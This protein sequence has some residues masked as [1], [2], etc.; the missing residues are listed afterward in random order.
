MSTPPPTGR[1][2]AG[3]RKNSPS[4]SIVTRNGARKAK[5]QTRA[6]SAGAKPSAVV[7]AAKKKAQMKKKQ[8]PTFV[9]RDHL[10]TAMESKLKVKG[11]TGFVTE[12]RMAEHRCLWDDKYPESPQRLISVIERCND[13][14]LIDQCLQFPPRAASKAELNVLHSPSVY[15]LLEKTHNNQNVEYLE[16]VSSR[17][18][19]VFIHPSTHELALI[20]AGSTIDMVDRIVSGEVQNGFAAVRPPGHHAMHATPCGYCFYN[21]VALAA[22]HAID[23]RGLSRILIVDWDVHHG[24]ATQQMF[25]DDPKV[26]YFSIHRYE[27]GAFWP[28]LKQS[29]FH[30]TGCGDG[31]G[32]TFN[33]P[34]NQTGMKDADYL[35]IWFQLLLPMA[36]EYRPELI[37]ISAG[38]DA[39]I[40]C[41]EGEMELTPACYAT[42]LH[43][44]L[45]V[46]PAVCVALEGGYCAPSL[47]EG[48]A[49][50]L[51]TLLGHPPPAL[52]ALGEPSDSVRESIL[53]CIYTHKKFWGCYNF[54]PTYSMDT[55]IPNVCDV[56]KE[57]HIVVVKWEGDETVPE[58]YETR[59]CYPIQSETVIKT[60]MERL[61]HLQI[62]TD[63]SIAQHPVCYIYDEAM[64][65]H[66]N[67]CEPGHV[68]C[69]ERILR[70]HER[71]RDFG[72]LERVV[73]VAAR[74]ATSEEILAVHTEK[75]LQKLNELASTKLRDLNNQKE[76]Y[77]SVYF[78]PDSLES[79]TVAAGCVL[80]A[81][82]EVLSGRAGSGVCVVRPPGHHADE[83]LPSGFCLL[84]NVALAAAHATTTHCLRRVLI[85][86]WDVHHGNGTQRITY[87]DEKILYISIHRYDNGAFFPHSKDA[88]YTAVGEGR[89]KGF[90]VNVPWNKRGMGDA[91]YMAAMVNVVLPIAYEFQPQLVLVSAGFDA[92]VGDPLGGCKVTPECYGRMTQ[93]LKGLAGGR[94]ILCLEGGYNVTSISYAMTMC[95]K[96]LL[97]DPIIHHYDPKVTYHPSAVESITNVIKVHKKYWKALKFQLAL[98]IEDVIEKPGPSLGLV[99]SNDNVAGDSDKSYVSVS[100]T[101]DSQAKDAKDSSPLEASLETEMAN[102]SIA[103]CEDGLH[104]GSDDESPDNSETSKKKLMI[105]AAGLA[106]DRPGPSEDGAGPSSA[107]AGPS[108]AGAGPSFAGAGPSSAGAG[109]SYAEAG[110]ST[111]GGPSAEQ[112]RPGGTGLFEAAMQYEDSPETLVGFLS[113]N[114]GAFIRGEMFAVVPEP[115]CPHLEGLP[116]VPDD[117]EFEQG[118]R[119]IDCKRRIENWICLHCYNVYCSRYANKHL[120]R[121][122]R[123]T[124]HALSL[125]LSDLSV[126]CSACELYLDSPLL[127][128]VRNN[129][130]RCKFGEDMPRPNPQVEME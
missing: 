38:Y 71:H 40:G 123:D 97:G 48:A 84:N 57:K 8:Q 43:L 21:N 35:A 5:I 103:K 75:H 117:V 72:L 115:W 111:S 69:P 107:G 65:K 22:K 109:P 10:L 39:A 12:P 104:C 37:I 121:H 59:D 42:L 102:M 25:Y 15:E 108:D 9:L 41:P 2:S 94:I 98:P 113:Q 93:M 96:A 67:I 106:M 127:Y 23:K 54:Q 130:H 79:A 129:A 47:A 58:R 87:S 4:S 31:E 122:Y 95:T 99:I 32:Y 29:N 44:L 6:M 49:L 46:C 26:V 60:I 110:P 1:R 19:A 80:Q 74:Q 30:Y 116:K 61:N 68:E 70:I 7:V 56:D 28:N 14:G 105:Y 78:H 89:G 52:E 50:T 34:L 120:Q 118:S 126:W 100:S 62:V 85:L 112:P 36:L 83:E 63:L 24:Q 119:C 18:D 45:G 88:D 53:N 16:E 3:D 76:A 51:R 101:D 91:E 17:F 66:K 55:S 128:D 81:V 27:H 124:E 86:D 64:L 13:L 33:V 82:D 114:M 73:Q 20:A 92:C 77:D 90:N 11:G 125:S